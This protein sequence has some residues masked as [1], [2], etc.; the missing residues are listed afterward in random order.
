MSRLAVLAAVAAVVAVAAGTAGGGWAY[1]YGPF[2]HRGPAAASAT[3][4]PTT[5]TLV[6][7]GTITQSEQD[8]GTIGYAGSFAIYT[9][10]AGTVTWL[11]A[12][13]TVIRPGQRLFAVDG[14]DTVL[15]RG[16]T[17]AWR[18]FTPGMTAG[19]DVAELQRNMIALG[20]DPYRAITVDGGYDWATQ[21]A[22]E[23]WQ[24]HE[25]WPQSAQILA[26]QVVF[27]SGTLRVASASTATGAMIAPG[28]QV[29]SATSNTPVVTVSLPAQQQAAVA[30]G[31]RITITLPDGSATAGRVIGVSSAA[32]TGSGGAPGAPGASGSAGSGGAGSGSSQASVSVVAS[33]GD[34]AT[35]T[36]LDG[37]PVQVAIATQTQP[38]ALIVPISALLARTGGGYQVTVVTGQ[39][40][41]N[42][43]VTLGVFD[44][45]AGDVA[46]SGLGIAAGTRVLVASS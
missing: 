31:Q 7:L 24:A 46:I 1:G 25:G 15:M 4:M 36:G 9:A 6:S 42:V 39:T 22:V 10:I 11:P 45:L 41:R 40:Q 28:A 23:R 33:I 21:A 27:Q 26:G 38:D 20:Y 37:A 16:P 12:S 14:Q 2:A 29:L 44:D 18:A 43:T 13:G 8:A 19:V 35:V 5:T 34:P 32:S 3:A 30:P 17:P